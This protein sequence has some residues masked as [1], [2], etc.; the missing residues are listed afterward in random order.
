MIIVIGI[1]ARSGST[2]LPFKALLKI[3]DKPMWYHAYTAARKTKIATYMLIPEH[4]EKMLK[5][6]SKY[7]PSYN[8]IQGSEQSPLERYQKLI[9]QTKANIIIRLTSDCPLLISS[10]II[11]MVKFF[12]D[13]KCVFLYNE[14]DGLDVQIFKT[15]VLDYYSHTEHV[16]DMEKIKE[17][18]FYTKYEMH[19]S[20]DTKEQFEYVS[21][22]KE[23][24]LKY[25]YSV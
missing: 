13:K 18:G 5:S 22:L 10:L 1:Q 15:S 24:E 12:N 16:V 2:R 19:L 11:D 6:V 14:L 23:R 9:E 25:E 8:I 17:S 7:V 3:A 4:D 21:K 20:V